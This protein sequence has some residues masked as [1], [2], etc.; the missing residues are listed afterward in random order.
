MLTTTLAQKSN[1]KILK[2]FSL[3]PGKALTRNQIKEYTKIP[4][5]SLDIALDKLIKEDIIQKN[6]KSIRLNLSNKKTQEIINFLK[7]ESNELR[8][9]PYKIWL[10]LF[11]FSI[12]I[13]KLH[14]EK[15][16]LFG[17]WAKHI[18]RENSDIDIA[19]IFEKKELKQELN[20]EKISEQLKDKH[21]LEIQLHF[22]DEKEFKEGKG[23]L[24]KE[25]KTDGIEIF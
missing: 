20:A 22:F 25:I 19:L 8:E 13:Q 14:F 12:S 17:S 24:L 1:I 10:I 2:L 6:R 11:D 4:N 21:D 3:A 18:A 9:I 15:A 16:I 7:E 23:V 5:V